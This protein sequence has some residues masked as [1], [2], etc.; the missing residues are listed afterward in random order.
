MK[1][2]YVKQL[3]DGNEEH[4]DKAILETDL[5]FSQ[6]F[7]NRY[8]LNKAETKAMQIAF[9]VLIGWNVYSIDK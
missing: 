7:K 6:Y 2:L 3:R 8:G 4:G 5:E 9:R 1:A